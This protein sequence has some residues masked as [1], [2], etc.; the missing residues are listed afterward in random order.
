MSDPSVSHDTTVA[1][2]VVVLSR[3]AGEAR[4]V[5]EGHDTG[6]E[7]GRGRYAGSKGPVPL[8][9]AFMVAYVAAVNAAALAM[10]D[11]ADPPSSL[12]VGVMAWSP[13]G[14][15]VVNTALNDVATLEYVREV[16][17]ALEAG[18]EEC[19]AS[20]LVDVLGPGDDS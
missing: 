8:A 13:R 3:P 6:L 20:V 2:C 7:V 15:R 19:G 18:A 1:R 5:A 16:A 10:F 12:L 17:G 14:P 11:E 9:S 4:T